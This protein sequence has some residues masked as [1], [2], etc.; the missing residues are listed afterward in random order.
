LGL[1]KERG[2]R[3]RTRQRIVV[4]DYYPC[5]ALLCMSADG[6]TKTI[7]DNLSCAQLSI[8]MAGHGE[9]PSPLNYQYMGLL[10]MSADGKITFCFL[11][12]ISKSELF[13][14]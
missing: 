9:L 12:Y 4:P 6:R 10:H 13:L 2:G 5:T 11:Q 14:S 1:A 7:C 8:S 3:Q